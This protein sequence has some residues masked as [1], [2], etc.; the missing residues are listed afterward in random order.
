MIVNI[1]GYAFNHADINSFL[2][3]AF[4]KLNDVLSNRLYQTFYNFKRSG[5]SLFGSN[6]DLVGYSLDNAKEYSIIRSNFID[7][8]YMRLLFENGWIFFISFF[9]ILAAVI[10][11][12][13]KNKKDGLL[14]IAFITTTFSL[15]NP[16]ITSLTFSIFCLTIIP[17]LNDL[18]F[19]QGGHLDE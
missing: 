13:Y 10:W 19:N 18:L 9:I 1:F 12:L 15:L 3:K 17:V 8:E 4:S 2:F 5:Y 6:I 16:R 7:N 11:Y 14:F